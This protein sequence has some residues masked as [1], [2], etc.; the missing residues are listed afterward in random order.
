[1]ETL[2]TI[3][4]LVLLSAVSGWLKKRSGGGEGDESWSPTA[5]PRAPGRSTTPPTPRPPPKPAEGQGEGRPVK[6][7][8]EEELRRLLEGDR[9]T[10]APPASPPKAPPLPPARPQPAPPVIVGPVRS[11]L[12]TPPPAP[13]RSLESVVPELDE[14][15]ST[16][17]QQAQ[18]LQGRA[19]TDL[20]RA[21]AVAARQTVGT[22]LTHRA[23]TTAEIAAVR[24]MLGNSQTARQAVIASVILG[25]PVGL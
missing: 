20:K 5:P 4:V 25:P 18:R 7:S 13:L 17:R 10:P 12:S 8:W 16:A 23:G 2:L 22:Q 9:P 11:V 24:G 3:L 15:T 14:L 21:E 6:R 19:A 1:M